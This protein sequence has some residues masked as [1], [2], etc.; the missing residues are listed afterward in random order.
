MN[1]KLSLGALLA[2]SLIKSPFKLLRTA[3][4]GRRQIAPRNLHVMHFERYHRAAAST[5]TN[6]VTLSKT[7]QEGG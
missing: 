5:R 7:E 4:A 2:L 6:S 1:L 3:A